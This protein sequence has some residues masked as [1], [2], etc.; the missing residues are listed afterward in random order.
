MYLQDHLRFHRNRPL[1]VP[2]V[3]CADPCISML[4]LP[5]KVGRHVVRSAVRHMAQHHSD[6]QMLREGSEHGGKGGDTV[7]AL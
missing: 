6:G 2:K 1:T 4:R 7:I 5:P 3:L